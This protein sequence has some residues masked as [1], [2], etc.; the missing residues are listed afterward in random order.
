MK[1]A[2]PCFVL[3]IPAKTGGTR[4]S[5]ALLMSLLYEWGATQIIINKK[6]MAPP[7]IPLAHIF[8]SAALFTEQFWKALSGFSKLTGSQRY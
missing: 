8:S 6:A 2:S 3:F 7:T 5:T 4:S 1:I